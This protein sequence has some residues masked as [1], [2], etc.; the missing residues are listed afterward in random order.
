MSRELT[1]EY[2][3]QSA[4]LPEIK[5]GLTAAANRI[6]RDMKF[7]DRKLRP[8]PLLNALV[9]HFLSRGEDEQFRIARTG[10][11]LLEEILSRDEPQDDLKGF[12]EGLSIE[13]VAAPEDAAGWE[14]LPSFVV[15]PKARRKPKAK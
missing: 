4:S 8:G 13:P 5:D 11:K 14:T 9:A 1:E 6:T 2:K 3:I 7:R 12:A 15:A 10:V